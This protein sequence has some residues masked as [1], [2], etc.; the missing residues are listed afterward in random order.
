MIGCVYN[1][2]SIHV[3]KPRLFVSKPHKLSFSFINHGRLLHFWKVSRFKKNYGL[4]FLFLSWLAWALR[5]VDLLRPLQQFPYHFLHTLRRETMNN[6]LSR[7]LCK[8][9]LVTI[10][11]WFRSS[12]LSFGSFGQP[13][14][15]QT[16]PWEYF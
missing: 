13:L 8:W 1:V 14:N 5:F 12:Q 2:F 11:I 10:L 4:V 3:R 9:Q 7:Y 15:S 6:C 16:H